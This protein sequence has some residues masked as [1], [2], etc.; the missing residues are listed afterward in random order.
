LIVGRNPQAL[1]KDLVRFFTAIARY[2]YSIGFFK[3]SY[4]EDLHTLFAQVWPIIRN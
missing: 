3:T 2:N 1:E 4:H